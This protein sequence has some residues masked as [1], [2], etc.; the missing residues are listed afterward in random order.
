MLKYYR[1]KNYWLC[2]RDEYPFESVNEETALR[3]AD[4]LTL[5]YRDTMGESISAYRPTR[6]GQLTEKEG[7]NWIDKNSVENEGFSEEFCRFVQKKGLQAVNTSYAGW[8]NRLG[9]ISGGKK[10]LH[11]LALGDV[12]STLLIGLRLMGGDV[13][14]SIGIFDVRPEVCRRWEYEL[15]QIA[16]PWNYDALPPVDIIIPEQMFDCNIFVFCASKGVPAIG[17]EQK[18]VRMVQYE[19][20]RGLVSIYAKQARECGFK[21]LFAVVSDPVDQLCRAAFEESNKNEAG[22]YD[23]KGLLPEQIEGYGLGVMNARA[24]FY[25]ERDKR[26]ASFLREGRAFGPHGKDLVIANSIEH[27]DDALS[28]EL[29]KLA[30]EANLRTRETGYKPYIA[31]A[32]SSGAISILLTLRGEWHYSA[33]F[34][35]GVYLGCRSRRTPLGLEREANELPAGLRE[36][37]EI[38][39]RNLRFFIQ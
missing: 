36:R 31:P 30:V 13:L 34:L 37:I 18:D 17:Q 10:R 4:S 21:G 24:A 5:L 19:A 1:F 3:C 20:N 7:L 33:T 14:S 27:Y 16:Y 9:S 26:F 8:E 28:R 25:A 38:A 12:G 6:I 22:V 35:G 29:T 32:L 11:L 2:S 15:N 23:W 39:Y